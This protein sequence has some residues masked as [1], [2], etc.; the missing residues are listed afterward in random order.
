MISI[1]YF[2]FNPTISER[3]KKLVI[4]FTDGWVENE[5]K[6][7]YHFP[8]IMFVSAS[9]N[10]EI[11]QDLTDRGWRVIHQDGDNTWWN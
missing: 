6:N 11:C 5:I 3:N 10:K 7:T 8:S 2:I 4:V 1:F 9:G